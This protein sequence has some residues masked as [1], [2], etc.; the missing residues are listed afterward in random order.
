LTEKPP[1]GRT[2]EEC[3]DE[4]LRLERVVSGLMSRAHEGHWAAGEPK[5]GCSDC[6]AI[7]NGTWRER[8]AETHE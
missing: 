7:D 1:F 3:L 6:E 8:Y 2:L 4:T 5:I